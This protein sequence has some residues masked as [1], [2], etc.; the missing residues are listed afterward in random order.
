MIGQ[1]ISHY[2]IAE[3]I[4]EGAMGEVYCARD[5]KL[6]RAVALKFIPEALVN[7]PQRLMRFER[8]A[9]L[10]A[11]LNH[12]NIAAI[13][14][15][16]EHQGKP[17]LVMELVEGETLEDHLLAG[18]LSLKET[19]S[20]AAQVAE[21]LKAAHKKNIIHRDLKPANIKITAD[22][23]VKVL[24]FGLA[25]QFHDA[26]KIDT[27]A[28]TLH[29]MTMAGAVVGT[30][31]YM[32]PEQALG[33]PIDAR[34]DIFSFGAIAYEMLTGRRPFAGA[35]L[36]AVIQ[37]L[38]GS[39]P[40]SPRRM[41]S[42]VPVDL[43]ALVMR[44]LQKKKELRQQN[45]EQ[46]IDEIN[47]VSTKQTTQSSIF[48]SSAGRGVRNV[49]WQLR[50]WRLEHK[51][52]EIVAATLVVLLA[53]GAL[54][55]FALKRRSLANAGPAAA[56]GLTRLDANASAYELFQQGSQFLERYD[57]EENVNAALQDFQAALAKDKN[58]SP[59]Y[60]GLGILYLTK[61]QTNRD[62]QLLDTAFAN[63]Q[64]A[65]NLNGQ[66]A[67][68][69]VSLG[70]VLVEKGEYDKAE[71][72]LKEALLVDPLNAQAHRGL[73][74]VERFRKHW[75]E[76]ETFY[77]RAIQL[78]PN[79]WDLHFTLGNFYFRQSRYAEAEQAFADVTKLV[80]DCHLGYRNLGGSYHMQGRF[81]E[82]SAEYQKALQI[83][84]SGVTYSNLG[85]SLFF[86]GLYQQ[87]VTAMEQAVQLGAN[88]AQNWANLGDAYRWTPGNEEKAKQAYRTA[89]QMIRT[90]LSSKPNDAD[91]HSRLA[92]CLSKSSEK[93]DALTEAAA[94]EALDRSASVLSRLV[95]VYEMCARRRQALDTMA[96]ALK[97]GY[98]ME[99]FRRDPELL[100]LR[101]DPGFQELVATHSGQPQK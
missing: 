11:S 39:N 77:K 76:A 66:L 38:V 18:P 95:S 30:P 16:E 12:T 17:V 91:L 3:K 34:A 89:I 33:E 26:G 62:K 4:G 90:E 24:D 81:A 21:A 86:Q 71:A 98:S 6:N 85:T 46:L 1:T 88:N 51:R 58:F 64:Q 14:G 65:V 78:R 92:L 35:T 8:E 75:P 100:E 25:K 40:Q 29:A 57:K 22:G 2:Q 54:G 23:L 32:S 99:E 49:A 7:E 5:L 19:L 74:D 45:A 82:A 50:T 36:A 79:D 83:K 56:P 101:K 68:N 94:A 59:A 53:F 63:A 20:I 47:Q 15:V 37:V 27:E 73:G 43:D 52:A 67:G 61:Y 80:P 31:A 60:G 9:Q 42:D 84:P 48:T 41:R 96:A 13:Y 70:R 10:L 97:A 93:K 28:A 55:A 72:E 69:R 44:S 87:S